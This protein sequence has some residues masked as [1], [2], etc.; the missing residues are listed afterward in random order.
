MTVFT[1]D[2]RSCI[3]CGSCVAA[4][5]V[6]VFT[7]QEDGSI[8]AEDKE[9]LNCF[10]CTAACPVHAVGHSTMAHD[11]LYPAPAP[12]GSLLRRFQTRRSIRH[13]APK[14]PDPA[15]LQAALDGAA[16]APSAKNRRAYRWTVVLG[17][18]KVEELYRLSMVWAK[19]DPDYRHLTWLQRFNINPVTCGAPALL[20]VH[21]PEA[22]NSA[23]T[24][25]VI[26][27]TL[28]E[29]LLADSGLGT[30]WAGYM[31]RMINL[32]GELRSALKLPEDHEVYGV[33]M[34]GYPDEHY[35]GIPCRPA[36]DI[37]WIK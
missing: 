37:N 14:P 26:A 17:S 12:E 24:D 36:A 3:R 27:M 19:G 15:I 13:F 1:I 32:C 2:E 34:V 30:C 16:Y 4:C 10:H 20:L 21:S 22:G 25:A 29:Q 5:P 6:G 23:H 11:A 33:L 8:S 28:A 9:C 31:C 35:S 18:E 7:R